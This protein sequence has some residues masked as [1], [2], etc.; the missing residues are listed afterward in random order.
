[1][2]VHCPAYQEQKDIGVGFEGQALVMSPKVPIGQYMIHVAEIG[3]I[4][5]VRQV[6]FIKQ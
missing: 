6:C 3:Q 5:D 2:T 4:E 1:M